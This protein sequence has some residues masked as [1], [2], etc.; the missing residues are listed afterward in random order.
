[1]TPQTFD[2]N[3]G[4][5]AQSETLAA[6]LRV[7]QRRGNRAVDRGQRTRRPYNINH[8][9]GKTLP[10]ETLLPACHAQITKDRRW[11]AEPSVRC[12]ENWGGLIPPAC[13]QERWWYKFT[14]VPYGCFLV[15]CWV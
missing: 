14:Q 11:D 13:E 10:D 3:T 12:L 8:G 1:M 2:H 7:P 4:T 15:E 9:I 5:V 6:H